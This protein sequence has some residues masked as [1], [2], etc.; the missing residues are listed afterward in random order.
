MNHGRRDDW[1]Q[2]IDL[3]QLDDLSDDSDGSSFR[4]PSPTQPTQVLAHAASASSRSSRN[5]AVARDGV[6]R[7]SSGVH[8]R[9]HR[10][11]V[12]P[13]RPPRRPSRV[14]VDERSPASRERYSS[15]VFTLNN[16]EADYRRRFESLSASRRCYIAYS[17]E[18]APTTGTPHL[19]GF[20]CY[21]RA[22]GP[23]TAR[24]DFFPAHVAGMRGSIYDSEVYCSK[25]AEMQVHGLE[26]KPADIHSR[27]HSASAKR[28]ESAHR[29]HVA[30]VEAATAGKTLDELLLDTEAP[31][32]RT[33]SA[34]RF[35]ERIQCAVSRRP[36]P[37]VRRTLRELRLQRPQP[38]FLW[39][40]GPSG[41]GK[42][43]FAESIIFEHEYITLT[44]SLQWFNGYHERVTTL[45][46]D[47]LK[48]F[49]SHTDLA[50]LL[51]ILDGLTLD[52]PTKGGFV[53]GCFSRVIVTCLYPPDG[54]DILGDGG[55]REHLAEGDI[56]G[57]YRRISDYRRFVPCGVDA[58]HP[59][60]FELTR[61]ENPLDDYHRRTR[62]PLFL[63][64]VRVN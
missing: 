41:A 24:G 28:S 12:D 53:S 48:V 34:C 63:G 26:F 14:E 17:L 39:V 6:V 27:A 2:H 7:P 38:E 50:F 3:T 25:E 10:E 21:G 30:I 46:L 1:P 22:V 44:G 47:E 9:V 19:Q 35:F 57:L 52:L 54:V 37:G 59:T 56:I 16:P 18:H 42:T 45:W 29:R 64:G 58:A 13:R 20:V 33:E 31:L 55:R 49:R 43:H 32:V 60:G 8:R 36:Q 23:S 4:P 15:Y 11:V 51:R 5:L 40:E 61:V 62:P